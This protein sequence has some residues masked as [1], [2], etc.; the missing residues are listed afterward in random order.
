MT[1]W[2][3]PIVAPSAA[4]TNTLI[5]NRAARLASRDWVTIAC[6]IIA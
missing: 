5:A 6:C 1:G 4:G 3:F 2:L